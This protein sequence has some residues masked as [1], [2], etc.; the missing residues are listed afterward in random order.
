MLPLALCPYPSCTIWGHLTP[1]TGRWKAACFLNFTQHL[2]D[3]WGES[4]RDDLHVILSTH[5]QAGSASRDNKQNLCPCVRPR[6]KEDEWEMTVAAPLCSHWSQNKR[7]ENYYNCGRTW[8]KCWN[9]SPI[10]QDGSLYE[11][12][13]SFQ[14]Q[15]VPLLWALTFTP[16]PIW[17]YLP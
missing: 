11:A 2:G 13:E 10:S 4:P 7:E 17:Q 3:P 1:G 9:E 16:A 14:V 8:A 12:V 5:T 6:A 15:W